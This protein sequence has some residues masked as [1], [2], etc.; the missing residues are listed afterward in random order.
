MFCFPHECFSKNKILFLRSRLHESFGGDVGIF[1]MLYCKV[2]MLLMLAS[3]AK[4]CA[5]RS[6]TRF[7]SN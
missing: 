1:R 7:V 6:E 5:V 4:N 3:D 2:V